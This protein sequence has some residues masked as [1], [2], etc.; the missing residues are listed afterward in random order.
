[1]DRGEQIRLQEVQPAPRS[2]KEAPGGRGGSEA[3]RHDVVAAFGY[4]ES[5][6]QAGTEGCECLREHKSFCSACAPKVWTSS[7]A[8]PAARSCP[9]TTHSMAAAFG[10]SSPG[11]SRAQCLRPKATPAPRAKLVWRWRPAVQVLP[12][13]SLASPTPR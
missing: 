12:T 8:T 3:A 13:W 6:R 4:Q 10:T 1:M 11:T 5:C 2:G 7:L 9:C